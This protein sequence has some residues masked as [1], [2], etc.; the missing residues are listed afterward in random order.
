MTA[1]PSEREAIENMIQHYGSG[2]FSV[3]MDSYDYAAVG[4]HCLQHRGAVLQ[5]GHH[6]QDAWHCIVLGGACY[7]SLI[8]V[9]AGF[10]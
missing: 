10:E 1:W 5:R 9:S 2:L 6:L 7:A 3:V 4:Q 8:H